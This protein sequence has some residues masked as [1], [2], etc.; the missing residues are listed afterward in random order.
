M[1]AK[2]QMPRSRAF[3][4]GALSLFGLGILVG[5][6]AGYGAGA[7]SA[8]KP[9]PMVLYIPSPVPGPT[10]TILVPSPVLVVEDRGPCLEAIKRALKEAKDEG[11]LE[12]LECRDDSLCLS[13][14]DLTERLPPLGSKLPGD[15][16]RLCG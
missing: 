7:A 2:S 12:G 10:Q 4:F 15:L 13:L 14:W 5:A 8:P 9:T 3:L 6:T 16:N 11:R 1:T